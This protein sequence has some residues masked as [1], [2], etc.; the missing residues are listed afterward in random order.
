MYHLHAR[1]EGG[2]SSSLPPVGLA[3]GLGSSL[4]SSMAGPPLATAPPPPASNRSGS[5]Q[6]THSGTIYDTDEIN[7]CHLCYTLIILP[8]MRDTIERH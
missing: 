2:S 6:L 5:E 1:Y 4:A 7:F 3:S 8:F